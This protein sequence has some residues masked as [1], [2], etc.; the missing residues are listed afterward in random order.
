MLSEPFL[1]LE[2]VH[3]HE[4]LNAGE[5]AI[6]LLL[7]ACRNFKCL[8]RASPVIDMRSTDLFG[9]GPSRKTQEEQGVR[10]SEAMRVSWNANHALAEDTQESLTSDAGLH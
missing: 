2:I 4:T 3:A 5:S 6:I 10:Q 9:G 8:Q 7:L 1:S